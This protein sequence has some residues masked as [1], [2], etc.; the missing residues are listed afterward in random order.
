MAFP[1]NDNNRSCQNGRSSGGDPKFQ[2][3]QGSN[4]DLRFRG[5][6]GGN[7]NPRFQ[8]HQ[9]GCDNPRCPNFHGGNRNGRI[10]CSN[11]DD[12]ALAAATV[13]A[14]ARNN[15][16]VNGSKNS[17]Q[18]PVQNPDGCTTPLTGVVSEELYGGAPYSPFSHVHVPCC[19]PLSGCQEYNLANRD[20]FW[21]TFAH[22]RWLSC[23][24][25][26]SSRP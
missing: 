4:G 19:D 17:Q 5:S 6:C 26:Y 2:N 11:A 25:L 15:F 8:S 21:P 12:P 14:A 1:N 18:Q 13:A 16:I 9:G 10:R 24:E 23:R 22:P 3:F 20:R 7:Y